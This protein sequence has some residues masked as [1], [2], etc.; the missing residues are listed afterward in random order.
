MKKIIIKNLEQIEVDQLIWDIEKSKD[1]Y[2]Y[3]IEK[4]KNLKDDKMTNI[5][6]KIINK[7]TSF[8]L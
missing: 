2:I 3:E 7:N 4:N 5:L 6:V 8:E 1:F